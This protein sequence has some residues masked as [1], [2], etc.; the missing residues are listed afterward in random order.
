MKQI[1]ARISWIWV[2]I[3]WTFFLWLSRLRNVV[4]NDEFSSSAR[5]IRIGIVIV[6]VTLAALAVGH[7]QVSSL[8]ISTNR[9]VMI[10]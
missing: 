1:F 8:Q 3:G 10:I 2:V 9:A 6:F 4:T 5:S 7:L